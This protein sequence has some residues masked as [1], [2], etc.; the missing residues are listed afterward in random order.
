MI[1][2]GHLVADVHVDGESLGIARR[3]V[4]PDV[5]DRDVEDPAA[6]VEAVERVA[7][8]VLDVE[9][10][11]YLHIPARHDPVPRRRE[12]QDGARGRPRDAP[13]GDRPRGRVAGAACVEGRGEG[14]RVAR[15]HLYDPPGHPIARRPIVVK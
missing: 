15:L 4:R 14:L 3:V 5:E 11:E 10:L 7:A 6:E 13:E 12:R 2:A 1:A 9:R 8:R